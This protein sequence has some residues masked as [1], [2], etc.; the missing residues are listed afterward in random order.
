MDSMDGMDRMDAAD[1]FR[2]EMVGQEPTLRKR[3]EAVRSVV[4]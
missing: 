1:F 4:R 2:R 3:R